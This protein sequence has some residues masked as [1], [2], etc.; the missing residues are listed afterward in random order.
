[1]LKNKGT[2]HFI[3]T[4]GTIDFSWSGKV[5]TAVPGER[6]YLPEFFKSMDLYDD[7]EFTELFIKD[8]RNLTQE[9]VRKITDEV[10]K[11]KHKKILITHGT[12]TMPDT[13]RY[14]E[15]NL[16]R[17]D[18]IIIFTGSMTPLKGFEESDASF[19]LGYAVSK[20][21]ELDP[22][23]YICMNGETFTPVEVVKN[24]AEG[25]FYSIFK[26]DQ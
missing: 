15:A 26:K 24:L 20:V 8:S 21:Q 25:K 13:A 18:Q 6:S 19:N 10:E 1:M 12:Y 7:I 3:L 22:G 4:G 2:I 16:T 23:I 11:S 14:L 5:D 17:K 9:D